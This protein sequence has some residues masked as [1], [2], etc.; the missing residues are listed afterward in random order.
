MT[1][2]KMKTVFASLSTCSTWSLQLLQ[3]KNS[4]QHGTSYSGREITLSPDGTLLAFV[5]EIAERYI[6]DTNGVI[7]SYQNEKTPTQEHFYSCV[8]VLHVRAL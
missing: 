7:N 5:S 6:A 2:E 3:I 4:R 1:L 8:G